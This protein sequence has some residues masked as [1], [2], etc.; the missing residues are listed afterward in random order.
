MTVPH[1]PSLHL[2]SVASFGVGRQTGSEAL[3]LM[4][5]DEELDRGVIEEVGAL[6]SISSVFSTRFA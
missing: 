5:V 6:S 1:L 2:P 4:T 3:C